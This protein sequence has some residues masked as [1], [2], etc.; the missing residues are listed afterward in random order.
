MNRY[1]LEQI[2]CISEQ[3]HFFGISHLKT[4]S[5]QCMATLF[6]R[7]VNSPLR[8]APNEVFVRA[9]GLAIAYRRP[10]IFAAI[11]AKWLTRI[12]WHEVSPIPALLFAEKLGLLGFLGHAYYVHLMDLVRSGR[13]HHRPTFFPDLAD[14]DGHS[15]LKRHHATHLLAGYYSLTTYWK[16]LCQTALPVQKAPHCPQ[17]QRCSAIWRTRWAVACSSSSNQH[18]SIPEV[19]ILKRLQLVED[20]LREDAVLVESLTPRCRMNA[21]ETISEQRTHISNNLYHHFDL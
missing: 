6:I 1:P 18:C 13:L 11:Q 19:D 4:W 14:Y 9:I 2:L 7:T 8:N 16:S 21:L 20:V 10:D 15:P 12:L 3:A 5:S 17:H